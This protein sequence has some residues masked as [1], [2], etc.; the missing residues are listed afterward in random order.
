VSRSILSNESHHADQRFPVSFQVRTINS[1]F[2]A[3]LFASRIV[4]PSRVIVRVCGAF[5]ILLPIEVRAHDLNLQRNGQAGL[6]RRCLAI[7]VS[8]FSTKLAV[9]HALKSGISG[10]RGPTT[11]I[12]LTGLATCQN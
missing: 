2:R 1:D 9:G 3:S 5:Y 8:H 7:D 11:F 10:Q 12:I 6:A 4:A